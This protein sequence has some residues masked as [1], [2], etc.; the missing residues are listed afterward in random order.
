MF[1]DTVK[2]LQIIKKKL[3]HLYLWKCFSKAMITLK[4]I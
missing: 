4:A 3:T 2:T 1:L